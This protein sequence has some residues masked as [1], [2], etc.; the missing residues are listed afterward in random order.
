MESNH[1]ERPSGNHRE[2]DK[3][4]QEDPDKPTTQGNHTS[5][6]Q[7]NQPT[8]CQW[9]YIPEPLGYKTHLHPVRQLEVETTDE[10]VRGRQGHFQ[11]KKS[12]DSEKFWT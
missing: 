12:F 11:D 3:E 8:R 2:K 5:N 4:V 10:E 9:V 1:R 6:I 7:Q